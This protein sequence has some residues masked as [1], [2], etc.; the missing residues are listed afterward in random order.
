MRWAFD[1]G[2]TCGGSR[3]LAVAEKK[4]VPFFFAVMPGKDIIPNVNQGFLLGLCGSTMSVRHSRIWAIF[5]EVRREVDVG[6]A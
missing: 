1:T 5:P 3:S 6:R 2:G 4:N